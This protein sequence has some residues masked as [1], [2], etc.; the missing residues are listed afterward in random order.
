M[1]CNLKS[2]SNEN[3]K[4]ETVR[5][6]GAPI[7]GYVKKQNDRVLL[8]M[9]TRRKYADEFWFTL[10]HEIGHLLND[11]L[12]NGMY[13]EFEGTERPEDE[14][15]KFAG[16]ELLNEKDFKTFVRKCDF[17]EEAVKKF[18]KEQGVMPFIV[19]GRLQKYA[20]NYKLL[21]DMKVR[22]EWGE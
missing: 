17:S 5:V 20:N 10:F 19:V 14:A 11:D 13:L 8:T 18:A 7:Q 2:I 12:N 15:D 4:I 22:Y 1:Q 9:T 21:H 3:P 6:K 16:E